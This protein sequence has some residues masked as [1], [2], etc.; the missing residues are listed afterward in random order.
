M[1]LDRAGDVIHAGYAVR[2]GHAW[3]RGPGWDPAHPDLSHAADGLL[4]AGPVVAAPLGVVLRACGEGGGTAA[5]F[6]R[7]S[8]GGRFV[9][10]AHAVVPDVVPGRGSAAPM[11]LPDAAARPERPRMLLIDSIV[12]RAGHDG[13]SSYVLQLLDTYDGY[14]YAPTLLPEA[15]LS[16]PADVLDA[17]TSRGIRVIQAPFAPSSEH[18]ITSTR[19]TYAVVVMSRITCGGRHLEALRARWPAARLVFHPVDLYHLRETRGA[20]L[21]DDVAGFA[22]ALHT[23]ARELHVA[24]EAD[25]TIVVSEHELDVLR[26]AG[27]GSRAAWIEPEC[28]GRTPA[29]YRPRGRHGVAFIGNYQHLPNVDAVQWLCGQVWPLVARCRPDIMLLL[30]G[31]DMPDEVAAYAG[32]SVS[33]LGHVPDLDGLLDGLRLTVAPLRYGAGVKLKLVC[34][35]AA[36]VPVV[37]TDVAAEGTGLRADEGV[38]LAQTAEAFADAVLALHDDMDRLQALSRAGRAAM[39]RFSPASVRARYREALA[40]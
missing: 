35:L 32:P 31:A 12:P 10:G 15:E 2:D 18:Y 1:V 38:V 25:A 3:P 40:L 9:P 14:G 6:L 16:A 8:A 39:Q 21:R 34:S 22:A 4:T 17:V 13:G 24:R 20:V 36:G 5:A 33:V 27:A 26:D 11:P 30:V 19:E 7:L 28:T 23:K 29:P 37:C